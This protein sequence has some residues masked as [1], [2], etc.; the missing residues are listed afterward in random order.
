M[1]GVGDYLQA[2]KDMLMEHCNR[3][4]QNGS[5]FRSLQKTSLDHII[6]NDKYKV[7]YCYIPKVACTNLKRIFLVLSGK[8]NV[9][10]ISKISSSAVHLHLDKH[11]TYLD[12]LSSESIKYRLKHY[13]KVIFVREPL[14]RILSAYRNKFV[15]KGNGYF[16]KRFG[17]LVI[18]RY[19]KNP[20]EKSLEKG[21]DMKFSEFVD[22]IL[23]PRTQ[24]PGY[25]EH[26]NTYF[27]LCSPC[28]VLYNFIGKYETLDDDVDLLLKQLQADQLV[29]FPKRGEMYKAIKTEYT[30]EQFYQKIDPQK[31]SDLRAVYGQ[32]YFLFGYQIPETIKK[33]ISSS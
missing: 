11:L 29:K 30:L 28:H 20:S 3:L 25:N 5:D 27:D 21:H 1:K 19:R 10:D 9:T 15:Q 13:R 31:I 24:R 14:E 22:Y 8:M 32:D 12:T 7:L 23:D 26:W 16:K 4:E 33:L 17:R 2:R 6:V 18:K